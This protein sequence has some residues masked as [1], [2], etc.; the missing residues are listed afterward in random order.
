M[1][2]QIKAL[3]DALVK[4]E[5]VAALTGAEITL[6]ETPNSGMMDF[7]LLGKSGEILPKLLEHWT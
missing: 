7:V 2:Q 3:R 6:E 5:R 1:E 4:A